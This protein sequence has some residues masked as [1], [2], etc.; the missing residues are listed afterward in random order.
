[1]PKANVVGSVL[2][3]EGGAAHI[4]PKII[5]PHLGGED[6]FNLLTEREQLRVTS[7]IGRF[8]AELH[9]AI[10]M[11]DA[12]A[13]DLPP[14]LY[15]TFAPDLLGVGGKKS[16]GFKLPSC[17]HGGGLPRTGRTAILPWMA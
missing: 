15:P 5:G 17:R 6:H 4:Y 13:L 9:A 2:V 10:S 3:S 11:E 16:I 7:D 12:H 8:L 1:M 14:P